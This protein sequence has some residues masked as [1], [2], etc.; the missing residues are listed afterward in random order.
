[1]RKTAV[2]Q[3]T[4]IMSFCEA[5]HGWNVKQLA[6]FPPVQKPVQPS[7]ASIARSEGHEVKQVQTGRG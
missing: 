4:R 7:G 5:Y 3:A 1:M 2:L 6:K